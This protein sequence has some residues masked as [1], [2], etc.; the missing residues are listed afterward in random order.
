MG[1]SS[2]NDETAPFVVDASTLINLNGTS[3]AVA[4]LS[5]IP[6]RIIVMDAVVDE[7]RMD[8]RS[9]RDDAK[10]LTSL[11]AVG[12]VSEIA[13]AALKSNHFERL[14][15]GDTADTLDDGEAATIA[16]AVEMQAIA[17]IDERKAKR[18][19]RARYP[20]LVVASTV[21]ILALDCVAKALGDK[22]LAEAT[23][24]ALNAARMRVLPEHINW[25]V[26]L[27]GAERAVSCTSL[28]EHVR[29]AIRRKIAG[30]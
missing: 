4:I 21:D 16:C 14:V 10:L 11:I 12:L 3:C 30:I 20:G 15:L 22:Q 25:V 5:A 24:N 23:Y 17:V 2:L 27:I 19:C 6:N 29:A 1:L 18:I 8:N 9:S 7:L 28:P 13:I 26:N